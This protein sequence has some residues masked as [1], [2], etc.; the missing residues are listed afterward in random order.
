[1]EKKTKRELKDLCEMVKCSV[2]KFFIAA[3]VVFIIGFT[4]RCCASVRMSPYIGVAGNEMSAGWSFQADVSDY[5]QFCI[6]PQAWGV[7]TNVI[8]AI[9]TDLTYVFTHK[10]GKYEV[11]AYMGMGW[12]HYFT[13]KPTDHNYHTY[14]VGF[15]IHRHF[16][17]FSLFVKPIYMGRTWQGHIGFNQPQFNGFIGIQYF[18]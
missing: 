7:H 17:G 4:I 11:D 3:I 15:E 16:N 18:L 12:G 9:K 1:M 5:F 8:L 6:D 14:N 13:K 10:K 2:D